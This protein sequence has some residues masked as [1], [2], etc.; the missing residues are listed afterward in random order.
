MSKHLTIQK[1]GDL[2]KVIDSEGRVF[3][4]ATSRDEAEEILSLLKAVQ[5]YNDIDAPGNAPNSR[6][7]RKITD[8]RK[9]EAIDIGD[10]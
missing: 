3:D 7:A 4:A 9:K 5:A 1:A 2:W 8:S 10:P 6:R